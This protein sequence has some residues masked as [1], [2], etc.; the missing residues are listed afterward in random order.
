[1]RFCL[2]IAFATFIAFATT[3]GPLSI[4]NAETWTSP[5]GFLSVTQPNSVTFNAVPSPPSPFIGLWVS[6]D[7]STRLGVTKTPVPPNINLM[8]T[9]AEEGLAEQI[10]GEVTR[11]S[12]AQVAG[13]E[14]WRMN[15]KGTSAEITQAMV[16]NDGTVYK[17]MAVTVGQ[18][19]DEPTINQFID[20]LAISESAKII[21][22]ET[23][24]TTSERIKNTGGGIDLHNLSK[25]IGGAAALVGICLLIFFAIRGKDK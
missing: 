12:T 6:N 16:R 1:M 17:L 7:D 24:P 19:P 25:T 9:A 21:T 13:Y 3:F 14:V 18:K 4:A 22:T 2:L 5:D 20:S 11:L 15:A 23:R 8:Q 10:G